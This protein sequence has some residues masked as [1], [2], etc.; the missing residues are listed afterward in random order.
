MKAR[1]R[2]FGDPARRSFEDANNGH[3][4]VCGGGG[5]V[6]GGPKDRQVE[7][8]EMAA[9]VMDWVNKWTQTFGRVDA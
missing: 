3:A 9:Q 7:G 4:D 5:G 1:K 8:R 6:G 2:K